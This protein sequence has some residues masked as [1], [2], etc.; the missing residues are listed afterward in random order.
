MAVRMRRYDL[1]NETPRITFP[2]YGSWDRSFSTTGRVTVPYSFTNTRVDATAGY[3]LKVVTLEA[4]VRRTA[5]DRTFREVEQTAET[6]GSI[7]A[8]S[9][10]GKYLTS[11][12]VEKKDFWKVV[13]QCYLCDLCYMT[14]CPY[15]PPHEFNLDFPHLM[16]RYRAVEAKKHGVSLADRQLAETD[17][18]GKWATLI[19]GAANWATRRDNTTMRG[20]IEKTAGID[21][22][23]QLPTYASQSLEAR[24]AAQP[25]ARAPWRR[26]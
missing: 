6:A 14:K 20:L 8:A 1:N 19:A 22:N 26:K 21:R 16:L 7:A 4:G 11:L 15:V 18:N 9:P 23:A 10:A 2:G 3:D 25:P 24:V 13:D 12:G 17:R 5:I